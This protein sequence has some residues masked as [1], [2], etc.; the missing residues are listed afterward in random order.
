MLEWA[1]FSNATSRAGLYGEA[2]RYMVE[3]FTTIIKAWRNL[4]LCGKPCCSCGESAFSL[5]SGYRRGLTVNTLE[6]SAEM[7][8][9]SKSDC[10]CDLF[11]AQKGFAEQFRRQPQLIVAD[12]LLGRKGRFCPEQTREMPRRQV[13]SARELANRHIA[14][15]L[16][17]HDLNCCFDP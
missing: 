3:R 17:L 11:H 8:S 12:V 16:E 1:D 5:G 10:R 4:L 7:T 6:V 13:D 2:T 14:M 15:A 9:V